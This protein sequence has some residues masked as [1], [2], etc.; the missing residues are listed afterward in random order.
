V[1]SRFLKKKV[2]FYFPGA[3]QRK[4]DSRRK[5][6]REKTIPRQFLLGGSNRL[7]IEGDNLFMQSS[8]KKQEK[9]APPSQ[10]S[11]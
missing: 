2:V 1:S 5:R 3:L 11:R 10:F 7:D 4:V 8:S 9:E 6:R